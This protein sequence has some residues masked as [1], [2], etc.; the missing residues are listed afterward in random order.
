MILILFGGNLLFY[1]L[2]NETMNMSGGLLSVI[3]GFGYSFFLVL[4]KKLKIPAN[5]GLLW[6]LFGYGTIYLSIPLFFKGFILPELRIIPL[7][8][9]LALIPT[10]CGYY[11]TMKALSYIESGKVQLFEMS[12]PLF[13]S[14]AAYFLFNEKLGLKGIIGGI[15]IIGG[16]FIL[17]TNIFCRIESINQSSNSR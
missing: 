14:F 17:Q 5:F 12:E 11:F 16:I 3:A 6:W 4:T 8:V 15:I 13:A 2:H 7:I 10:I 9:C 1:G